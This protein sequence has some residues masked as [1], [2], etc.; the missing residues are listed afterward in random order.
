MVPL[1]ILLLATAPLAGA[2]QFQAAGSS[3]SHF[4]SSEASLDDV[5]HNVQLSTA[6][7]ALMRKEAVGL[8]QKKSKRV[9]VAGNNASTGASSTSRNVTVEVPKEFMDFNPT[10]A[11]QN[12]AVG[13]LQHHTFKPTQNKV[14]PP[15]NYLYCNLG[16]GSGPTFN[17]SLTF[18]GAPF[19]NPPMSLAATIRTEQL[20]RFQVFMGWGEGENTWDAAEFRL[21]ATG[22]LQYGVHDGIEW[23][24][25]EADPPINLQDNYAH[26]VVMVRDVHGW[27]DLFVNGTRVGYGRITDNPRVPMNSARSARVM[28]GLRDLAFHGNVS[29]VFIY[30]RAL[31]WWEVNKVPYTFCR[32]TSDT[33][34]MFNLNGSTVTNNL[35]NLG[36]GGNASYTSIVTG[37]LSGTNHGLRFSG[38]AEYGGVTLD[39]LVTNTTEYTP[40]SVASNGLMDGSPVGRLN[41]RAGTAVGLRFELVAQGT[42][43]PVNVDNFYFAFMDID[44]GP[45]GTGRESL[46]FTTDIANFYIAEDSYLEYSYPNETTNLVVWAG[47]SAS[48]DL[49]NNPQDPWDL[50]DDQERHSIALVLASTSGFEVILNTTTGVGGR[51]ISF[52]GWSPLIEDTFNTTISQGSSQTL[53]AAT[54]LS[55]SGHSSLPEWLSSSR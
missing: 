13:T 14:E 48:G 36:D 25:V 54:V 51:E 44:M 30:D 21:S 1:A 8:Q 31:R 11:Y 7:K 49:N 19:P 35:G 22:N 40:K 3:E 52:S 43:F 38:V 23:H 33:V 2:V 15:T 9:W 16:G 27:V 10:W 55:D 34:T 6:K 17:D 41:V 39:L 47:N 18:D 28:Y 53:A 50:T 32:R 20:G 45:H 29:G 42:Y 5:G 26:H 12:G 24:T 46:T 4:S 37:D